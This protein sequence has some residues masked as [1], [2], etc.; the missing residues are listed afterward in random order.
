[1]YMLLEW[2]SKFLYLVDYFVMVGVDISIIKKKDSGWISFRLLWTE[3]N[4]ENR[5]MLYH[6]LTD[7]HLYFKILIK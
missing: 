4:L 7:F 5:R 3:G 6:E 2:F 1:M